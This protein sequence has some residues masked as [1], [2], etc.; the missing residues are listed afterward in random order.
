MTVPGS[1]QEM[2]EGLLHWRERRRQ[3]DGTPDDVAPPRI[4]PRFAGTQ[5]E[6]R[7]GAALR[8]A[9]GD[10][11]LGRWDQSVV[12]HAHPRLGNCRCR[13]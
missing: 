3:V 6:L 8:S 13:R 4:H 12:L 5:A 7:T 9:A 2:L 1:M 10:H 11:A